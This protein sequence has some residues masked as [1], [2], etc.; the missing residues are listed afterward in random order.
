MAT[1][2]H[3][4]GL[5]AVRHRIVVT[6][7]WLVALVAVGVGAATLSGPTVNSFSIPGQESTI[8]LDLLK[9]RF[10]N[11][12]AGATAQV[13]FEAPA[14]GKITDPQ[15]AGQVAQAVATLGKL[16]GVVDCS[17]TKPESVVMPATPMPTPAIAVS[18][19]MPAATSE[20]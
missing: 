9:Q 11:G 20:P 2:L 4:L 6:I 19:F 8:A 1:L 15:N 17:C 5:A 18:R 10:G 3:R 16:P 7:A 13:V 12:S 14:G